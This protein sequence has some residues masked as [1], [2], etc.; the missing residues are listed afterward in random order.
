MPIVYIDLL[1]L[2]NAVLDVLLLGLTAMLRGYVVP[3]WRIL[4]AGTAGG[5]LGVGSYFFSFWVPDALLAACTCGLLILAAWSWKGRTAF[6]RDLCLLWGLSMVISGGV[7]LLAQW[8]GIGEARGGAVYLEI[9]PVILFGGS[10]VA[11]LLLSRLCP[12]GSFSVQQAVREIICRIGEQET[13]FRA[14]VDTGNL[15]CDE[16]GRKVLLLSRS[17]VTELIG[18]GE[19]PLTAEELYI[20]LADRYRPGLLPYRTAGGEGLLVTL[21]PD[22]LTIDGIEREDY[23]LGLAAQELENVW[24]CRGLIGC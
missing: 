10:G 12:S 11:Y 14:L 3:S 16:K 24:G 8:S 22:H 9:S 18:L 19:L 23:I 20:A 13:A 15:L 5:L 17:L 4:L 2:I 21:R 1:F 7:L 6:C